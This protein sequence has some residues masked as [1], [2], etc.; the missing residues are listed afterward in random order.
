M[1]YQSFFKWGVHQV[2][3]ATIEFDI[4]IS[5]S[6]VSTINELSRLAADP[7]MPQDIRADISVFSAKPN[8][9]LRASVDASDYRIVVMASAALEH[10]LTRARVAYGTSQTKG[11]ATT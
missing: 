8:E 2:A 3:A 6:L 7:A 5:P 4:L 1:G 11:P 9:W 10:L